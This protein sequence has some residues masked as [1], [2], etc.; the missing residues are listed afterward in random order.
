MLS[1]CLKCKKRRNINPRIL[2]TKNDKIKI[3][4]KY[5]ICNIKKEETKGLL[6]SLGLK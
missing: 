2:K 6:S 1:C 4:P 5:V 3:L